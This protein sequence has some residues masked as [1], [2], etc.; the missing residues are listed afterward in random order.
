MK[1]N[2]KT[3]NKS[4]SNQTTKLIS[5]KTIRSRILVNDPP[6]IKISVEQIELPNGKKID[7][8]YQV[9]LPEYVVI[10]AQTQEGL[11][12]MERQ[13]KHAV[14]KVI[15][16]LPAGYL[17]SDESPVDC[18]Q[19]EL[20]EETGFKAKRWHHLGSFW[21]DGNRGC[22]KIHAFAASNAHSVREPQNEDTEELEV[23]L[24]RPEDVPRLLL[25]GK[26]DTSGT[27]LALSLAFLS[28]RSPF[29][30]TTKVHQV[31]K[32]SD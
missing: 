15:L 14:G 13:Y 10:V 20:L 7:N 5:W 23:I 8:F 28:P 24:K 12:I 29:T 1:T 31:I 22:G 18:A 17:D 6:W 9:H 26:V 11:I 2:E 32:G 30:K 4:F 3:S 21:V 27:A 16:N 25:K 19:R